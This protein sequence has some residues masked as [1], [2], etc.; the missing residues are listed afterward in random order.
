MNKNSYLYIYTY[1]KERDIRYN[2]SQRLLWQKNVLCEVI[3]H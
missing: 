3:G 1:I 2:N